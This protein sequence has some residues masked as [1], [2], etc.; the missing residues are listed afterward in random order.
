MTKFIMQFHV[1]IQVD[2]PEELD[3]DKVQ[4]QATDLISM[5]FD[6]YLLNARMCY[7]QE[8]EVDCRVTPILDDELP[9]HNI[10]M[11]GDGS[12]QSDLLPASS[13]FDSETQNRIN[14]A[15]AQGYF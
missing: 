4:E 1:S 2:C 9:I 11:N 8:M 6:G 5:Q 15:I 7:P 3:M 10:A 14:Q 12:P 13:I